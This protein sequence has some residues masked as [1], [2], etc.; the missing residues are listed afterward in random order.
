MTF[1]YQREESGRGWKLRFVLRSSITYAM[2]SPGAHSVTPNVIGID[3]RRTPILDRLSP[4]LVMGRLVVGPVA[5]FIH[6]HFVDVK[7]GGFFQ[8][9]D[10]IV[11]QHCRL[12]LQRD[13]GMLP[14]CRYEGI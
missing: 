6:K 4:L 2:S 9:L 3:H 12:V 10:D 14:Y 5:G 11:A 13:S 1:P 8:L 7:T